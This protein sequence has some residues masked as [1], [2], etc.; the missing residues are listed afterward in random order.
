MCISYR[1][2]YDLF[3]FLIIL[4][5]CIFLF[6]FPS[7]LSFFPFSSLCFSFFLTLFAPP[8]PPPL[9]SPS[10]LPSYCASFVHILAPC[11]SSCFSSCAYSRF[12]RFTC[13]PW[14]VGLFSYSCGPCAI[15]GL[16]L[17]FWSKPWRFAPLLIQA[18]ASCVHP[19]FASPLSVL[20]PCVCYRIL[21]L[22]V[23]ID[24]FVGLSLLLSRSI[25]VDKR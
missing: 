5:F 1:D 22:S 2:R 25:F 19:T 23:S 3:Q 17:P 10:I 24:C 4:L 21:V 13:D 18:L 11:F 14:L 8:S 12:M 9:P 7:P 15:V 16:L 6:F 20:M